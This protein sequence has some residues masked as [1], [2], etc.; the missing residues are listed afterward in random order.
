MSYNRA[1]DGKLAPALQRALHGFAKPW[2]RLR[3]LRVFRDDAS[4]S[5]NPGLWSSIER[6]LAASEFFV[7]LASPEAARSKWVEREVSYWVEHRPAVNLLIVLTY[8]ELVWDE[9]TG[10]FD[11]EQTTALPPSLRGALTEEPRYIDL[12][13][14]REEDQVSLHSSRFRECVADLAAPLHGVAKDELVGEDVRQHR[15]T[16]RLARSAVALLAALALVAGGSAVVAVGQRNDAQAKARLALSRQLAVQATTSLDSQVDRALLL[17]LEALRSD[18]T[19]EARAALLAGLQHNPMLIAPLRAAAPVAAVAF[20]PDG[21]MLASGGG[22]NIIQLWDAIHHGPIGEPLTGHR[23]DSPARSLNSVTAVAFSPDSRA[24]ASAGH[25]PAVLLWDAR[26]RR[27]LGELR[28][29]FSDGVRA[30]A[31][32][33]DGS[34]LATLGS[35]DSVILW[36]LQSRRPIGAPLGERGRSSSLAFSPDGSVLA[37]GGNPITLWDPRTGRQLRRFAAGPTS[38]ANILVFSPDGRTLASGGGIGDDKHTVALWDVRSG[39]LRGEPLLGH[40]PGLSVSIDQGITGLTFSPDGRTLASGGDDG[41]VLLWDVTSRRL[42]G[43]PLLGH[44]LGVRSLA[45]SPN[46]TAL[47][48]GGEDSTIALWDLRG[49]QRLSRPIAGSGRPASLA[50]SPDGVTVTAGGDVDPFDSQ[51]VTP[52]SVIRWDV[53]TRQQVDATIDVSH[54]VVSLALAPDGRTLATGDPDGGILLRDA[55]TGRS[56]GPRLT[57]HR[58]WVSSL[59][60]SPDGRLL[61]SSSLAV[62]PNADLNATTT[63]IV[64]DVRTH[65]RLGEPLV[66]HRDHVLDVAFSPDGKLLATASADGTVILWDV[67]ARRRVGEPLTGH[68]TNLPESQFGPTGRLGYDVSSLAFSPDGKLL[69]SGSYDDTVIL[70]DTRTRRPIGEPLTVADDVLDVAFS[71]DGRMLAALAWDRILLWDTRGWQALGQPLAGRGGSQ[72]AFRPDGKVLA[73]AG[74]NG[75][76]LWDTDLSSW[77]VLACA[78]ASRNLSRAEWNQFIGTLAPYQR[79][80]PQFPDGRPPPAS[81]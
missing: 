22:R 68:G 35:A 11:W 73:S 65:R 38:D 55:T 47:A 21:K 43:L 6:A 30:M 69:A 17:S 25:D 57:G 79:T 36:D 40:G 72:L 70:W 75:I 26:T 53:R 23:V 3:A 16:V 45:F 66:G 61:A 15:R 74:V 31:F 32:S 4:L 34:I 41:K 54:K 20:S 58:N 81:S 19:A 33:P 64:W 77:K 27:R 12:R 13:W 63:V 8:G 5:A 10:D 52:K 48:S 44:D 71:P 60:F 67:P 29:G 42:R 49:Q 50:F 62:G 2:Y 18:D 37:L 56:V 39:R 14:A 59:A 80:C 1:V 28:T 46:G 51:S 7:L 9:V 78:R 24:L 76:T